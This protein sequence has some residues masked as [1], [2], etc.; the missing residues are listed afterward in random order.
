MN[1]LNPPDLMRRTLRLA[2]QG[3]GRVHPNPLV[4]CVV[5]RKGR[6]VGEGFHQRFG[7]AHAEV[8]ALRQA[9]W[10]ARGA[11]LYVNLEPCDH[12]GK[13]PPCTEAIIKAGV[14]TVVAAMKDPNPLV[15][16]KGFHRLRKAGI[17][18]RVGLLRSEAEKINE[19]FSTIFRTGLPYVGL[20]I[21]QT[22]DG[23]TADFK[24]HSQ[25]IT[26]LESRKLGHRLRTE[27][28]AVLIGAGTVIA[29]NPRLTV[30]HGKGRN[31]VRIVLAGRMRIPG[32]ARVFSTKEARTIIV[33]SHS[34][35]QSNRKRC[36]ALAKKGVEIIGIR[37]GKVL[38]PGHILAVLGQYGISSILIEGGSNTA[39]AFLG[40]GFVHRI[41][42]FIA[43]VILGGGKK[44]LSFMTPADMTSLRT[45]KAVDRRLLHNDFYLEGEF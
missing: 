28:E 29:D 16:G 1:S 11:T 43:P 37:G 21:A 36:A 19:R 6:I 23:F 5:V 39:S 30:R 32:Y 3:I 20:K 2:A 22:L 27:Y 13:T 31:P 4:G 12:H 44:S 7:S 17:E 40:D 8:E 18:V 24:G 41:H 34:S 38:K 15:S 33:T 35:L 45:M 25:W 9:G 14:R 10:R 42:C 26:S